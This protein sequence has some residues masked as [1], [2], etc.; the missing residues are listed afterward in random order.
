MC[1]FTGKLKIADDGQ[2]KVGSPQS[3]LPQMSKKKGKITL[4]P[5]NK[6]VAESRRPASRVCARADT[7]L[8]SVW[9]PDARPD[10]H[11]GEGWKEVEE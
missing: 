11:A 7:C 8:H 3:G 6:S 1:I 4:G 9:K 5:M 2:L 10:P